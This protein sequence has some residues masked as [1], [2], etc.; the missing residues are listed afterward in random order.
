MLE[1]RGSGIYLWRAE[2]LAPPSLTYDG[3]LLERFMDKIFVPAPLDRLTPAQISAVNSLREQVLGLTPNWA[4]NEI[5]K[6]TVSDFVVRSGADPVLEW[7]CGYSSLENHTPGI[8]LTLV[9]IDPAVVDFHRTAGRRC[10]STD[11]D[12]QN[13]P[14][15]YYAAVVS[16]FVWHFAVGAE[17]LSSMVAALRVQGFVLTN[18]YRRSDSSKKELAARIRAVGLQLHRHSDRRRLCRNHE[19]W[20][21]SKSDL[22]LRLRGLALELLGDELPDPG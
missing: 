7:G 16:V 13:I 3:V 1:H 19:Y 5:V 2:S 17:H 22:P 6:R 11:T 4:T 20:L 21:M 15:S 10:Y 18:V 8:S 12:R 9:D 14:K